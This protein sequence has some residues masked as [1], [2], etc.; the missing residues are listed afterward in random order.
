MCAVL[1]A[2]YF[3]TSKELSI[4]LAAFW[5][6]LN[7]ARIISS[8]LAA[9]ILEMRGVHGRPGW[10]WLF[11]V[12]RISLGKKRTYTDLSAARGPPNFR[13]RLHQLPLSSVF[14]D[15][16]QGPLVAQRMVHRARGGDHG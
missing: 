14:A 2:T 10:F 12:S 15:K 7:V 9:G 4:R 6:T 5:S 3:Y 16:N 13:D 8:L 1:F 11:L